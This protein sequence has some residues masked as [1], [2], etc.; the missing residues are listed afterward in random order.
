MKKYLALLIITI[1]FACNDSSDVTDPDLDSSTTDY[2]NMDSWISYTNE[3]VEEV[4]VFYIHPTTYYDA[5]GEGP[6]NWQIDRNSEVA[7]Y[8]YGAMVSQ[9]S[10]FNGIAN[11]YAPLYQQVRVRDL[12]DFP[13]ENSDDF[14]VAFQ[15]VK[16]AFEYYTENN[17]GKPFFIMGH[18]QGAHLGLTLVKELF[19]DSRYLDK[20]IAAYIIGWPVTQSDLNNYPHLK[21]LSSPEETGGVIAWDVV[22]ENV[23]GVLPTLA[24]N[25]IMVNPLT[26]TL[27]KEPVSEE[28][29]SG[30]VFFGDQGIDYVP[31]NFTQG[32]TGGQVK[33]M[34]AIPGYI[35]TSYTAVVTQDLT[36]KLIE[37]GVEISDYSSNGCYHVEAVNLFYQNIV[38]NAIARKQAYL[39][40]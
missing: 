16:A 37:T 28:Y 4:D 14:A 19:S 12:D 23:T 10:I 22:S 27:T 15:D 29:N 36:Q 24:P 5:S 39:S 30:A 38:E 21:A 32:F 40:E 2:T 18:S 3:P 34:P 25:S 8:A 17:G 1:L 9:V 20:L 33:E 35:E 11:V 26:W 6:D 31:I 13:K 7:L